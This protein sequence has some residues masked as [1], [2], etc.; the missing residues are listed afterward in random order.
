MIGFIGNV[1]LDP[2][3][4]EIFASYFLLAIGVVAIMFLRVEILKLV[5]FISRAILE[6]VEAFNE[7]VHVRIVSKINDINSLS[8]VYFTKG[9]QRGNAQSSSAVCVG[10]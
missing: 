7:R 4:V 9:R 2:V 5:L 3:N 1:L 10:K 8:V 6:K